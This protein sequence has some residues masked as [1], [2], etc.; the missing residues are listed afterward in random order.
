MHSGLSDVISSHC[1]TLHAALLSKVIEDVSKP[2]PFTDR[3]SKVNV[4]AQLHGLGLHK[5]WLVPAPVDRTALNSRAVTVT[6]SAPFLGSCFWFASW[7]G[8]LR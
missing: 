8:I 1:S 4:G 3:L 5:R 6:P 7:I 2:F